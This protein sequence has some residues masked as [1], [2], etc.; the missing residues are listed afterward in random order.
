MHITADDKSVKR[1]YPIIA[2]FKCL[3]DWLIAAPRH[4]I[5]NPNIALRVSEIIEETLHETV[6]DSLI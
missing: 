4:I 5:A 6:F 3:T 2:L 1:E